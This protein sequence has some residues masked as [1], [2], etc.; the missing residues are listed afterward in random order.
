[1]SEIQLTE[2]QVTRLSLKPGDVLVVNFPTHYLTLAEAERV[3]AIF[4]NAIPEGIQVL[5]TSPEIELTVVEQ[6]AA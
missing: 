2:A 4:N 5:V 6:E 1:M 3:R